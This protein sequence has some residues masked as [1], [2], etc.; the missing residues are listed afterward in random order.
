MNEDEVRM[1]QEV[2][3]LGG[4]DEDRQF[5]MVDVNLG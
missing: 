2:G 5:L 1:E 4:E 3:G